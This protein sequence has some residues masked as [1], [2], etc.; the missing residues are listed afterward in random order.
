MSR[1]IESRRE[2]PPPIRHSIIV[3]ER[4]PASLVFAPGSLEPAGRWSVPTISTVSVEVI[5]LPP[6]CSAALA[7]SG[8]LPCCSGR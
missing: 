6:E 7:E 1:G 8:R 2:V 4:L 5:M 3:S